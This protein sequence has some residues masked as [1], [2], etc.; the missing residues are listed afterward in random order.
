MPKLRL[1]TR[2]SP[3]ALWQSRHVAARLEAEHEGL[4]VELVVIRTQGDETQKADVPLTR[5]DGKGLFVREIEEALSSGGIDLAVHSLKDLPTE[6]PSGL[7]L[8]AILA[9]ADPRDALLSLE[10]FELNELARGT[11]VATGSPRRRCQ[12]LHRRPDL[13]MTLVRGNVGTR[14]RKLRE[15]RFGAMVLA[16]AGVTRLGL[17]DVP[18]VPISLDLC[19]PAPGQGAIAVETR[20]DDAITRRLLRAIDDPDTA[21]CV[22][23][24]RS[25][26]AGL[27]GGCLAPAAA[28]ARLDSGRIRI[29]AM[30]GDPDGTRLVRDGREG[31]SGDPD[32]I[33]RALAATILARGGDRI[34]A[35]ARSS[36]A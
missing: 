21:A 2:G 27:G 32:E 33:G 25:F 35:D 26:L 31:G 29:E 6:Q 23:A 16:M 14:V 20:E 1:G 10:G 3:L 8:G 4:T 19:L 28:Y 15:G 17:R 18:I 11:L 36:G 24:E 13:L 12:I 34:L 7:I 9:R 22:S 30:V 5:G